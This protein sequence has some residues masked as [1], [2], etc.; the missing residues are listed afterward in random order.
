MA[1]ARVRGVQ[2]SKF[3]GVQI[4]KVLAFLVAEGEVLG[5]AI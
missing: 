5:N 3:R 2:I 4:S 1:N